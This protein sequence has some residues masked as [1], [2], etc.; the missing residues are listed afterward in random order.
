MK[1]VWNF[2]IAGAMLG[3]VGCS[4]QS[5]TVAPASETDVIRFGV[6]QSLS[7]AA[8]SEDPAGALCVGWEEG[9]AVGISAIKNDTPIGANYEYRIDELLEEGAAANLAASS[10]QYTYRWSE[11]A[12]YT[13]YGYY[14]HTGAPNAT[15]HYLTPV[16]LPAEQPQA[17]AN[18]FS[19]LSQW[20]VMKAEPYT[21]Q[22]LQQTVQLSFRGVF[23]IVELKLRYAKPLA[24]SRQIERVQLHAATTP[25]AV[26]NGNL[27]LTSTKEAE[28][29]EPAL[30]VNDGLNSVDVPLARP[31]TLSES[32][33]QSIWLL[34]APGQHAAGELSV[35]LMSLDSYHVDV[36]IPDAVT[37]EPNKVYR[38]EVV[39][40]PDDYYYYR[41]PSAPAVTYFK[42]VSTVEDITDGEYL[43]GFRYTGVTPAKDYLVPVAPIAR[44]PILTTYEAA[45][46]AYYLD[47]GILAVDSHYV[48]T[49]TKGDKG[50]T[51][52]GTA[53][54]G[55]SYYLLACN[56]AQGFSI[57]TSLTEGVY[58]SYKGTY[59]DQLALTLLD[60]GS[61]FRMQETSTSARTMC[62]DSTTPSETIRN[63]PL[64]EANGA[65]IL[66]KKVT[67]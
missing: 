48:W 4:S 28:K 45:N 32:D 30:I 49:V 44:N 10:S 34:V 40:N 66:Y 27:T 3:V 14:P 31:A 18:D 15:P 58:G 13:F 25:L 29:Q 54:N 63:F 6:S 46:V 67:E 35:K 53:A 37:F 26:V 7:R 42:Q 22:G 59:T 39:V 51:F 21:I 1:K 36:T 62:F 43:L 64:A 38:K 12:E 50:F 20:W 57:A 61:G 60:D 41:D 5:E 11:E 9:D 33:T 65:V 16:S 19:H 17:A 23:S 55:S 2:I 52:R 24:K 47:L 56:K 8:F